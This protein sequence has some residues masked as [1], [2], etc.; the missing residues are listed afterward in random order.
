MSLQ[1][2][3]PPKA[4]S[5]DR[6]RM[7][8]NPARPARYTPFPLMGEGWGGG[9]VLSLEG[10]AFRTGVARPMHPHIAQMLS[11]SEAGRPSRPH[12]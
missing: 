4:A 2:S 1:V 10:R 8:G 7:N 11:R 5:F 12:R 9:D 6:P 3:A